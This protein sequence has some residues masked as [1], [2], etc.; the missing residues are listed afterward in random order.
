[1]TVLDIDRR[2]QGTPE[3]FTEP[4]PGA[5]DITG[6]AEARDRLDRIAA[7]NAREKNDAA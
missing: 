1:M 4:P 2:A 5:R 3:A 7:E 6:G